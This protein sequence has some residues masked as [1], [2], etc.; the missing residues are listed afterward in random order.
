M[1]QYQYPLYAFLLVAS[2]FSEVESL[3]QHFLAMLR[4]RMCRAIFDGV[5]VLTMFAFIWVNYNISLT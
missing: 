2:L 4:W 1:Q 3:I 5:L